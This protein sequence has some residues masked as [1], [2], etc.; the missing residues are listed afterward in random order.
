[1]MH[2]E[3]P[4]EQPTW[5]ALK[6]KV[7]VKEAAALNNISEDTFR[8]RYPRLIRQVSPRRD[9]VELGDALSVGS[10]SESQ[11]RLAPQSK[12]ARTPGKAASRSGIRIP[13]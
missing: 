10:A 5:L 11:V 6:R 13:R 8:R 12:K 9:A 4:S 3:A 2:D 1:M 7:S